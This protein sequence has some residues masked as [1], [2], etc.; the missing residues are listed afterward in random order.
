[1]PDQN[2]VTLEVFDIRGRLILRRPQ[3]LTMAGDSQLPLFAR[4]RPAAGVYL[5]RLRVEDPQ[6]G[7]IRDSLTGKMTLLR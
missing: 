2:L 5:F 3:G 6:T 4:G 1:M 7:R